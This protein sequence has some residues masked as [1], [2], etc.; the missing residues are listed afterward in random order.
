[1]DEQCIELQHSIARSSVAMASQSN[2]YVA[3]AAASTASKSSLIKRIIDQFRR[4]GC[5]SQARDL[6]CCGA[7]DRKACCQPNEPGTRHPPART[8][9]ARAKQTSAP[10]P[11][12]CN[13]P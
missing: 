6:R 10:K 4:V 2:A 7:P 11:R 9:Y 8:I 13:N 3:S 12:A 5:S 1:C